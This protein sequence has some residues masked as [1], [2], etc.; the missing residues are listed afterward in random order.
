[1]GI[2]D[3]FGSGNKPGDANRERGV[4]ANGKQ[5]KGGGHDH[6]YNTEKDRTPAQREG[7]EKRR[8][9][10]TGIPLPRGFEIQGVV[11]LGATTTSVNEAVDGKERSSNLTG[12]TYGV[13]ILGTVKETFQLG[14][15]VGKDRFDRG[16]LT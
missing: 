7:D 1:M 11:F 8:S 5:K 9:N 10:L 14:L 13:G 12:A 4:I 16:S 2:F 3:F 15:V 6:R